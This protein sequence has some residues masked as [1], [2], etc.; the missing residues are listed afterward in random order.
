MAANSQP[1]LRA[2]RSGLT[3]AQSQALDR[4]GDGA[5]GGSLPAGQVRVTVTEAGTGRVHTGEGGA[6]FPAGAA[7]VVSPAQADTLRGSGLVR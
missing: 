7:L 3:P 2:R 6:T 4:D 5:A 1:A